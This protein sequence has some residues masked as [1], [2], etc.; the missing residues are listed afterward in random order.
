MQRAIQVVAHSQVR[1][2]PLHGALASGRLLAIQL[3]TM[4]HRGE[5]DRKGKSSRS[6]PDCRLLVSVISF[7]L[8]HA[9]RWLVLWKRRPH[10]NHRYASSIFHPVRTHTVEFR[11]C[12][13]TCWTSQ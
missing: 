12:L 5:P 4:L 6:L 1:Q 3:P 10:A 11:T 8:L 2:V 13:E 7:Y 9:S